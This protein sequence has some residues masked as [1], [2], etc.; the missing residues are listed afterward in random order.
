MRRGEHVAWMGQ[1]R[2]VYKVLIT[3]SEGTLYLKD[4]GPDRVIL[5]CTLEIIWEDEDWLYQGQD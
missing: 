2:N 4:L 3:N 1:I 5:N